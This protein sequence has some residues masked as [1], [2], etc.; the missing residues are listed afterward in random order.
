ME[1]FRQSIPY[2]NHILN[3]CAKAIPFPREKVCFF[4]IETTGLSPQVSSVYLI[5]AAW[6]DGP[7]A[8]LVQW[9]ADDYISEKELLKSFA[10]FIE[11]FSVLVH[12]NGTTFDIPYLEKKYCFHKLD[13]P[14]SSIESLDI[15]REIRRQKTWFPSPDRKLTTMQNLLSLSRSDS[16]SGKDCIDLYTRYMHKKFFCDG[17]AE[18]LKQHLLQHN[19]EDLAGTIACSQF[20]FY[21]RYQGEKPSFQIRHD[22]LLITDHIQGVFPIPWKKSIQRQTLC[23]QD[24]EICAVLPLFHGTLYHFYKDYKNY[25]Y[26]PEEDM[27]VH[28][29]VGIYVDPSHRQKAT[30]SN[31]YIKKTGTFLPLPGKI[32]E[33]PAPLFRKERRSP[34]S[35][36]YIE[37][38]TA[39]LTEDLLKT[40]L[41]NLF[42]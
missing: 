24:N 21:T 42:Q 28:K 15:Y 33:D 22:E 18:V 2:D 14:F 25:Y 27:A 29:S 26:L 6:F 3:N 40:I 37:K 19:Q 1:E 8:C 30:A 34:N 35:Y 9:F 17:E 5:G 10:S 11:N 32:T 7:S 20:L 4:D 36:L 13:N 31:C 16:Y 12:F 23:F 38:G 41:S 39:P